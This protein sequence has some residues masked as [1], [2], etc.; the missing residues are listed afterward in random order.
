MESSYIEKKIKLIDIIKGFVLIFED[1]NK[2]N[3][4]IS[5][6]VQ[7]IEKQQDTSYIN[8]LECVISNG[9]EKGKGKAKPKITRNFE[10]K[11]KEE[12][13]QSINK[14]ITNLDDREI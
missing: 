8:S 2:K 5:E 6:K 14:N 9:K 4:D 13:Y 11:Q 7:C 12:N 1:N 10:P 3:S